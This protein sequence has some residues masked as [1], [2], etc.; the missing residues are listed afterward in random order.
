MV[1]ELL[2]DALLHLCMLLRRLVQSMCLDQVDSGV[3]VVA[4]EVDDLPSDSIVARRVV[5]VML[6]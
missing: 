5:A 4:S 2:V 3:L 6:M 1:L